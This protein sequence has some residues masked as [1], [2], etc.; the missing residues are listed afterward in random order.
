MVVMHGSATF[1]MGANPIEPRRSADEVLHR[2]RIPRVFAISS[3]EVTTA[4]FQAY[5]EDTSV[6]SPF[7]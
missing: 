3:E 6:Q 4:Q 2:V 1:Q 7:G 5:L